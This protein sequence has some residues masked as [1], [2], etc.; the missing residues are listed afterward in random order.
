MTAEVPTEEELTL[1]GGLDLVRDMSKEEIG[2]TM[3]SL[4]ASRVVTDLV[5]CYVFNPTLVTPK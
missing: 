1:V 2:E 4:G 5:G 3:G